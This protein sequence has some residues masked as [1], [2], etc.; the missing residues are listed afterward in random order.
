MFDFN[1]CGVGWRAYD[2]AVYR[3]LLEMRNLTSNWKPFLYAYQERRPLREID[4]SAVPLFVAARY[5]WILGLHTSNASFF[6]RSFMNDQL[7]WNYWLKLI[8]DWD[9]KELKAEVPLEDL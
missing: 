2:I 1:C 5:I 4:L 3:W 6:G 8:R 9:G 7:Y